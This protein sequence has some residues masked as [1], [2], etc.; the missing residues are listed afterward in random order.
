M[1]MMKQMQ[2]DSI[3]PDGVTNQVVD[4]ASA[5]IRLVKSELRGR[6]AEG[7]S[8]TEVQAMAFLMRKPGASV[9]EVAEYLGLGAPTTSK[10]VDQLTN[11]G[12]LD[13]TPAAADRR[14]LELRPTEEGRQALREA[15]KPAYAAVMERLAPLAETERAA[16]ERTMALLHPLFEPAQPSDDE[17]SSEDSGNAAPGYS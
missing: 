13:R 8:Y 12:L 3:S 10:V 14:R 9:G 17:S 2:F 11:R 16:V 7:L 5:I 1:C 6:A 4:V 15:K